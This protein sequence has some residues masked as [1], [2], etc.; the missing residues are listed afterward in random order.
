MQAEV[1]A[2]RFPPGREP[3]T[4]RHQRR[5]LESVLWAEQR[6]VWASVCSRY[7]QNVDT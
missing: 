5:V 1:L 3:F 4:E 7:N 2:L 6:V